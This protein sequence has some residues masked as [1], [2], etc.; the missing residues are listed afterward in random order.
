[1]KCVWISYLDLCPTPSYLTVTSI[2]SKTTNQKHSGAQYFGLEIFSLQGVHYFLFHFSNISLFMSHF[3]TSQCL[4]L[5]SLVYVCLLLRHSY[6]SFPHSHSTSPG[7][8]WQSPS[9]NGPIPPGLL[10]RLKSNSK[11]GV[12]DFWTYLQNIQ[13]PFPPWKTPRISA[14]NNATPWPRNNLH[15]LA[16]PANSIIKAPFQNPFFSNFLWA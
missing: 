4:V 3:S 12:R 5:I 11:A 10:K 14:P 16:Y 8:P 7:S 6:S 1:M 9:L 13:C 2:Y 15:S